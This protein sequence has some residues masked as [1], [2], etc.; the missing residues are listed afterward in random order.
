MILFAHLRNALRAL[1]INALRSLLTMLG[2]IIGVSAVISVMAVGAGAQQRVIEQLRSLGANLLLVVPGSADTGGARLGSGTQETLTLGDA[3]AILQDVP[4]IVTAAPALF[5]RAQI[6]RGNLNWSSVVQGAT[7]EFLIAREWQ[8]AAGRAF[9][10][11]EMDRAAKVALLGVIVAQKLFGSEDPVGQV[12]RVANTPFTV[13]GV[14]GWKGQTSSGKDQDDVVMIPLATAKI[15]VLG[16][17]RTGFDAVHYV[18]VKVTEPERMDAVAQEIRQ[19]LRQRHR[20]QPELPDD[21]D[22]RNLAEMQE[23]REKASGVLGF[24]LSV[25]ASVSLVVGGISIMNI[26]LVSV[27]ER[28]GEIGLRLAV[29]AHPRDIRYQFLVESVMLSVFGATVGIALGIG[30]AIVIG[31]FGDVPVLIRP[32]AI[33]LASGF[34]VATG[35]FFGLYPAVRAS[36]LDPITALRS[37]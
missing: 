30:A 31:A 1:R 11:E 27:S 22:I 26:M 14:L 13:I 17:S 7:P 20:L 32:G 5:T 25:V 24:W 6:V 28:T 15:R 10:P 3:E 37:E 8:V 12:I 21:F 34:A 33:L 23:T 9:G 19:L 36:R 4:S 16:S 2:I 18:I 29:G 35:I